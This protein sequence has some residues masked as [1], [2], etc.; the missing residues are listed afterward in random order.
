MQPFVPHVY[1]RPGKIGIDLLLSLGLRVSVSSN[2][3][4]VDRGSR[5]GWYTHPPW[6]NRNDVPELLLQLHAISFSKHPHRVHKLERSSD[7]HLILAQLPFT[8]ST[9]TNDLRVPASQ[10]SSLEIW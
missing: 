2:E 3:M 8:S 10:L 4:T 1:L 7:P 9:R 5:V 6:S